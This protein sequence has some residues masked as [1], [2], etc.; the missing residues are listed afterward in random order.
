ME[1]TMK[2][3]HIVFDVDG[4]LL[5]TAKCILEALRDSLETLTGRSP[6]AEDLS[7]ALGMT[8]ENVLRRL[9]VQEE[10]IPSVIEMWVKKEED[11]SQ[12]IRPFPG[13]MDL[14]EQ[15][16]DAG[17]KLGIVTSRTHSELDLVF[18]PFSL[19]HYFSVVI[20]ADDTAEHKPSPAPLLTYMEKTGC[21]P[22]DILYVG[23][24]ANDMMCAKCAGTD[25]ALALWGAV[26]PE[27]EATHH[28]SQPE[29]LGAVIFCP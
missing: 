5:D 13:I 14:L 26:D 19:E 11:C 18:H 9:C 12:L 29:D 28:P 22:S 25:S 3:T 15:L 4:T 17:A 2:Y 8:S 16:K 20:C 7:F 23:D 6:A 21:S 24:S 10:L 27:T 1:I